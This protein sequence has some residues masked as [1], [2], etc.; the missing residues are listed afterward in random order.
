MIKLAKVIFNYLKQSFYVFNVL[1]SKKYEYERNRA[2][3]IRLTHAIEKGMCIR[4]PRLGYGIQKIEKIIELI[5]KNQKKNLDFYFDEAAQMFVGALSDYISFNERNNYQ[6]DFTKYRKWI[7]KVSAAS[8]DDKIGG[9]QICKEQT[10]DL[11][12]AR[13]LFFSRHSRRVFNNQEVDKDLL[14]DAIR[15][16]MTCPSACNRQSTRLY[17]VNH[18]VANP[19]DNWLEGTGGFSSEIKEFILICAKLSDYT[20]DEY[21]QYE[22]STGIFAGY[23]TL[24]LNAYGI[25]NC[26][27]QRSVFNSKQWNEIKK[28]MNIPNDEQIICILGCGMPDYSFPVPVSHRLDINGV[29]RFINE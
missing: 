19:L 22:V 20:I 24:A 27:I 23:L 28:K 15:L 1:S 18:K 10:I 12:T 25:G 16:S 26:V 3:I 6:A 29:C 21:Q 7:E 9:T 2:T 8:L 5:E 14:C 11:Q 17:V 13:S 4:S